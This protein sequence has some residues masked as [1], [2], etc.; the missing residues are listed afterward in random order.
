MRA[1]L[2]LRASEELARWRR[3]VDGA[4]TGERGR[5]AERDVLKR[6]GPAGDVPPV[7]GCR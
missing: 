7:H 1:E 6:H 5:P 3:R 2:A 4:D